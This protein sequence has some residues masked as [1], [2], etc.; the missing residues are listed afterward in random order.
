MLISGPL[1]NI[2]NYTIRV[3]FQVRESAQVQSFLWVV[4]APVNDEDLDLYVQ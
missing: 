4:N 3:E 1:S 2:K